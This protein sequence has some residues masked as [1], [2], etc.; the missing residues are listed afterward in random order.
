[1]LTGELLVL[2]W[3]R[4]PVVVVAPL[5]VV[6]LSLAVAA[7]DRFQSAVFQGQHLVL[8]LAVLLGLGL[9]RVLSDPGELVRVSEG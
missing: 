9:G 5:A 7:L 3:D 2:D 1:V 4:S 6:V 8:A